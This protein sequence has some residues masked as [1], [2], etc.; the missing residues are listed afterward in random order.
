MFHVTAHAVPFA[1][2]GLVF[3]RVGA[4]CSQELV[5]ISSLCNCQHTNLV[6]P[7]LGP[8]TPF[9]H[10]QHRIY[11]HS[12]WFLFFQAETELLDNRFFLLVVLVPNS[13]KVL[14]IYERNQRRNYIRK[15]RNQKLNLSPMLKC[16]IKFKPLLSQFH[17]Q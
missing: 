5:L 7:P 8:P 13:Q 17:H 4:C 11:C 14:N 10:I 9:S 15:T 12:S 16:K 2:N 1:W 6:T 3:Y